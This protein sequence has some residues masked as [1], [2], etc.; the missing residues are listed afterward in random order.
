MTPNSLAS[1]WN[2]S[3]KFSD[4]PDSGRVRDAEGPRDWDGSLPVI[5]VLVGDSYPQSIKSMTRPFTSAARK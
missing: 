4:E 2:C 3:P 5:A 1:Q